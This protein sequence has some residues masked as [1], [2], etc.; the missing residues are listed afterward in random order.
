MGLNRRCADRQFR[1]QFGVAQPSGQQPQYLE[2]S[3][4]Q[5]GQVGVRDELMGLVRGEALDQEA[6]LSYWAWRWSAAK[7]GHRGPQMSRPH[8]W[9]GARGRNRWA[10][11]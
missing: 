2:L 5:V 3:R 1:G 8:T 11:S 6:L 4:S 10:L 9:K 7:I